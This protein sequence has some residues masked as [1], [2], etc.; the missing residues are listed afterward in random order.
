MTEVRAVLRPILTLLT[1]R[2]TDTA[3][4]TWN[5]EIVSTF[6][7]ARLNPVPQG[8]LLENFDKQIEHVESF[9][10]KIS[11][12]AESEAEREVHRVFVD[13]LLHETRTGIYSNFH[14]GSL[15]ERGYG[16]PETLRL[17]HM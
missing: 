7:Q 17:A 6:R 10:T 13:G 14:N 1:N 4:L 2:I 16:H 11:A 15:Y 8:F 9:F 12:M 3:R 5:Q